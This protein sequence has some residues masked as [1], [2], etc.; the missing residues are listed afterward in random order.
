MLP[1]V[2]DITLFVGREFVVVCIAVMVTCAT[3]ISLGFPPFC[4]ETPKGVHLC[5]CVWVWVYVCVWVWV[6]V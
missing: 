2:R 4:A 5:G 1:L 6:W 3:L